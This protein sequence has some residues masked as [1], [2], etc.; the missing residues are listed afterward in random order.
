MESEKD[1]LDMLARLM[2]LDEPISKPPQSQQMQSQAISPPLLVAQ[3]AA[4]TL[5]A[6][7]VAQLISG[8][9]TD[10]PLIQAFVNGDINSLACAAT[11][12]AMASS[13]QD[14]AWLTV[15]ALYILQQRFPDQEDEWQ[16][17]AKKARDY[18]KTI[19]IAKPDKALGALSLTL[20]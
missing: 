11:V 7:I 19:G 10:L 9:W 12:K 2:M 1:E 15:L 8:C 20:V 17:L 4:P 6:L 14:K 5:Q 18:L 3:K 16:L 13:E